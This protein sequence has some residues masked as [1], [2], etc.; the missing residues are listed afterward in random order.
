[1]RVRNQKEELIEKHF[2]KNL[3]NPCQYLIANSIF[4]S[5][6][7]LNH[8]QFFWKKKKKIIKQDVSEF[9]EV[10]IFQY[11]VK[12]WNILFNQ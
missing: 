6:N 5:L 1:M 12:F 8:L 2:L 7:A 10:L 11:I 3:V 9:D 4:L